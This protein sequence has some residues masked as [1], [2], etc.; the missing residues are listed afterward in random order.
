MERSF[1]KQTGTKRNIYFVKDRKEKL[2][3]NSTVIHHRPT[4]DHE[5]RN[6]IQKQPMPFHGL[7]SISRKHLT[8]QI[9]I[10][11]GL[12]EHVHTTT[13]HWGLNKLPLRPNLL[14]KGNK[15]S[16]VNTG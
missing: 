16:D 2:E 11:R 10:M 15:T 9:G 14:R 1:H 7:V 6:L 5:E 12:E 4:C 3:A 13:W 8:R